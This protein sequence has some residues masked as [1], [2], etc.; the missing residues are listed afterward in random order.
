MWTYIHIHTHICIYICTHIAAYDEFVVLILWVVLSESGPLQNSCVKNYRSLGWHSDVGVS[1][2][3]LAPGLPHALW[4]SSMWR[5]CF[6]LWRP[7]GTGA[8]QPL[9]D[10]QAHW[11]LN[12]GLL[13]LRAA[14]W[15]PHLFFCCW[16][17]F[18]TV[19]QVSQANLELAENLSRILSI[20]SSCLCLSGA[21]VTGVCR[22]A[23][24]MW[25]SVAKDGVQ[26]L[27]P[28]Q[29]A[30]Y[31]LSRLP[32]LRKCSLYT[33]PHLWYSSHLSMKHRNYWDD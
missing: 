14:R 19:S 20:W 12:L 28:A 33:S 8:Q 21:G 6:P 22:Y 17:V 9:L 2:A 30:L 27:I 13:R 26:G 10:N 1:E 3:R 23:R 4:L 16:F 29:R 18:E 11:H 5:G 25:L 32:A 24:L 15:S 31:Q 7:W